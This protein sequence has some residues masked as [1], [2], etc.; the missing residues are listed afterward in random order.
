M[1]KLPT[2]VW[3]LV[4]CAVVLLFVLQYMGAA[5]KKKAMTGTAYISISER[6]LPCG[7][8]LRRIV[9]ER[10]GAWAKTVTLL[11][12]EGHILKTRT[13][14]VEP[15]ACKAIAAGRF[16]PNLWADCSVED[17]EGF[18][19]SVKTMRKLYEKRSKPK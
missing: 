2:S 13:R 14:S 17:D 12:P 18:Q 10:D 7:N 6:R 16:V 3:I 4:A 5:A 11:D 1:S 19:T 9:E 15:E 8:T